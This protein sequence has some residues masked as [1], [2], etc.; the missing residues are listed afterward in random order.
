MQQIHD[1]HSNLTR[2]D[3]VKVA[4]INMKK[5]LDNSNTKFNTI[6]TWKTRYL[7][8]INPLNKK[9][10]RKPFVIPPSQYTYV[11]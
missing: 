8:K 2:W 11:A 4:S 9:R 10:K 5:T 3:S 7:E 6:H 1:F